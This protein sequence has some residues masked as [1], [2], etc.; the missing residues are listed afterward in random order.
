MEAIIF[1]VY[2]LGILGKIGD[3]YTTEVGLAHGLA[4]GNGIATWIV[5]KIGVTGISLLKCMGFAGI[6]PMLAYILTG[7]NAY[8][9]L[10]VSG[11]AAVIGIVATVEN[12][13]LLKKNKIAL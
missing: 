13:L 2:S 9:L 1:A 6:A 12:Y 4:E 5:S 7:Q 3:T 8:A 11:P 10:A